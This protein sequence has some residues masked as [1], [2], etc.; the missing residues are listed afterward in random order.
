MDAVTRPTPEQQVA[1]LGN[2]QRLL[3]EGNFVSTYKHA[4]VLALADLSVELGDDSG[5]ALLLPVSVIAEKI[6]VTYWRQVLPFHSPRR[7]GVLKQNTGKQAA[8]VRIIAEAHQVAGG[9]LVV[10]KSN[11]PAGRRGDEDRA[12]DAAMEAATCR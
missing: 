6:V 3:A 8:I 12:D 2:L 4:L 5:A 11:R 7:A 10:A 1:F 9:S